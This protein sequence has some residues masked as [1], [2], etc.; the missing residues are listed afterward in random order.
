MRKLKRS[1]ARANM[2]RAGYQ[3]INRKGADKQSFFSLNWRK[4]VY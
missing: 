3:H 2:K 1:V 4:F